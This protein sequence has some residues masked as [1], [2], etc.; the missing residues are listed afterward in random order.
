MHDA[1]G[2]SNLRRGL[3]K[4]PIE[5]FRMFY[6]DTA[7]SGSTAALM[8]AHAFYGAGHLLFG[9]DMPF[10]ME[11]GNEAIRETIRSVEQMDI[12]AEEKTAIF[13][14][15]ARKLLHCD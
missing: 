12:T 2:G 7:V 1:R 14:G 8:C 11:L 9:T 4:E 5:Y 15:N 3:T 10:D 13:E 6:S